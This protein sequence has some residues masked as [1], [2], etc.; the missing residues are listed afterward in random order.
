MPSER[1]QR[2]RRWLQSGLGLELYPQLDRLVELVSLGEGA[3][4][5]TCAPAGLGSGSVVYSGGVGRDLGFER[6]L[7]ARFGAEVHAF[8]PTPLALEWFR[9]QPVMAGLHLHELGLGDFDGTARFAGPR[10]PGRESYS[11]ARS[12]GILPAIEAPVRRVSTLMTMLGHTRIDLLKLDIEGLEYGVIADLV[13]SRLDVR[14][15]LVE[16]HHRW[17]EIGVGRSREALRQLRSAGYALVHV[18]ASGRDYA[19]LREHPTAS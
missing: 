17:R 10:R 12:G 7:M 16:F 14:Q 2:V 13:R 18:S 15:L 9:G 4:E 1:W 5:W 8:D 6:Q 3:G 19:F 11:A